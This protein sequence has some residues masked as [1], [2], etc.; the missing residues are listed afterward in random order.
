MLVCDIACTCVQAMQEALK[1]LEAAKEQ[2]KQQVRINNTVHVHYT[3]L[4]LFFLFFFYMLNTE[5]CISPIKGC[6][7]ATSKTR[8]IK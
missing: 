8:E 5:S 1:K 7:S 2:H 4:F 6:S 3:L